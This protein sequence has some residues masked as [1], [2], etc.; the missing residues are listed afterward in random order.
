MKNYG[1]IKEEIKTQKKKEEP[2]LR[3]YVIDGYTVFVGRNNIE[4]DKITFS[5]KPTDT[6]LH[7]KAFHSSHVIIK[8]PTDKALPSSVIKTSAEICGYYSKARESGNTEIV[9]T[10]KK[11]VKKTPKGKPGSCIYTD[12][13]SITIK[14][15][16][17]E[18]L[19][20]N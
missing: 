6:W 13:N 15:Q 7:A 8:N 16:K 19:I 3:T 4:N 17:H 14:P 2:V 18:K 12:F 9:F 10:L 5:A 11:F 20:K 1:L